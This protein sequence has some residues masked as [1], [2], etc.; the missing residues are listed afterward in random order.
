MIQ[1]MKGRCSIH[2]E[3]GMCSGTRNG[4]ALSGIGGTD[5]SGCTGIAPFIEIERLADGPE[6]H[7]AAALEDKALRAGLLQQAEVMGGKDDDAGARD[8][9]VHALP[10]LFLEGR[11]AGA[12][13]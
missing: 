12:D 3:T 6:K 5:V 4:T 8:H 2:A 10:G 7:V 1:N 13:P 9:A 11:I